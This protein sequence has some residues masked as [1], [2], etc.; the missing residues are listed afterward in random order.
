MNPGE[1]TLPA[2]VMPG[3]VEIVTALSQT[4]ALSLLPIFTNMTAT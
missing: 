4:R 2:G 1:A 3:V